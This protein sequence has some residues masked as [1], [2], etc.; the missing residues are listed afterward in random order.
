ME[1]PTRLC[2]PTTNLPKHQDERIL[3]DPSYDLRRP[4]E[5]GPARDARLPA[6][7][8]KAIGWR[9]GDHLWREVVNQP[10]GFSLDGP[11]AVHLLDEC[12]NFVFVVLAHVS[13][14]RPEFDARLVAPT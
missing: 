9:D 13:S 3:F 2:T 7:A 10:L 4:D 12:P 5:L 8:A 1:S 14:P 6:F 11:G